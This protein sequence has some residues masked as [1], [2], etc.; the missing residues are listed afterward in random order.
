ME[1]LTIQMSPVSCNFI[2][3]RSTYSPQHPVLQYLFFPKQEIKFH[4]HTIVQIMSEA[5][6]KAVSSFYLIMISLIWNHGTINE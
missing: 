3:L 6:I 5:D 2:P 4:T 1:D